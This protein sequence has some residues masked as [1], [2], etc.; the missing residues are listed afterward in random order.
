MGDTT[1]TGPHVV[2]DGNRDDPVVL[3]VLRF[4]IGASKH[5]GERASEVGGSDGHRAVGGTKRHRGTRVLHET[6]PGQRGAGRDGKRALRENRPVR[7]NVVLHEVNLIVTESVSVAGALTSEAACG[8]WERP[9]LLL[10]LERVL[11][12]ACGDVNGRRGVVCHQK[13]VALAHARHRRSSELHDVFLRPR[14]RERPESVKRNV[15][16]CR[17]I[18]EAEFGDGMYLPQ[19]PLARHHGDPVLP[20]RHGDRPFAFRQGH[21]PLR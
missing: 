7:G 9:H 3:A 5:G 2:R 4:G 18:R 8:G 17:A 19:Q 14:L 20:A 21:P 10:K 12:G 15:S 11:L 6:Q 1:R 16:L 13:R